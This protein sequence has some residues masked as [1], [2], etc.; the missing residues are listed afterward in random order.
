MIQNE[1]S[2]VRYPSAAELAPKL[3]KGAYPLSFRLETSRAKLIIRTLAQWIP[4][5]KRTKVRCD[6]DVDLSGGRLEARSR[7]DRSTGVIDMGLK[8]VRCFIAALGAALLCASTTFAQD[9]L[10]TLE[11]R[12]ACTPDAFR[13]CGR[14]MPDPAGVESC[15]R[16]RTADLSDAC[17][18]VFEQSA[19]QQGQMSDSRPRRR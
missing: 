5:T 1:L 2:L 10:G 3:C 15:L 11:Q 14:Y 4:A 8:S 9:N 7:A 13:L 18:S 16:Q 12:A 19:V 17:R 6:F